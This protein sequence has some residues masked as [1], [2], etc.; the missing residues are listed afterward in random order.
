MLVAT[1]AYLLLMNQA[2]VYDDPRTGKLDPAC[3]LH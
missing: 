3:S 2:N 1:E